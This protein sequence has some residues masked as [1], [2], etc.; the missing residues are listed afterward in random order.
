[1]G[2]YEEKR[3][4]LLG[5]IAEY[6]LEDMIIAFSGGVDSS[7][8]LKLACDAVV[9]TGKKVY[10][11]LLHT[12]LHPKA[13]LKEAESVAKEA[14]ALFRVLR[15]DELEGAGIEE[16]PVDRCYRCKRYLFRELQK[17]AELLGVSRILEGTNEDDLHVYRPGIRAVRELGIV[18][19][20]ADAGLTK[21]D[22]RR[23][24]GE[25]GISVSGKPSTPCL[26]TRFPYGVRLTYEA[27][28]KVEQGESYLRSL[29]LGNVRLRVHG[30]LARLEVDTD[31]IG[32]VT[33][34]REDIAGYLKNLGY[35]YVT[36]D[37]EGFRTGSMD[38]SVRAI[39][40][41]QGD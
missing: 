20:L 28:R 22:V 34:R 37:L 13:E 16:N 15:I 40:V 2:S 35:N 10:G 27:M 18:S 4:A 41:S 39:A 17:E 11:I 23:L 14:G 32:R 29:G 21:S 31:E 6:A 38:E 19:P 30:N 5:R 12:M 24:T 9:K 3:E 26:A 8:L 1:M 25:Y 7:L 33:E 36:L